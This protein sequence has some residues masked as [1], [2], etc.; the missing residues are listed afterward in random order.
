MNNILKK[1]KTVRNIFKSIVEKNKLSV[2]NGKNKVKGDNNSNKINS[3]LPQSF[4]CDV[5]FKSFASRVKLNE[6]LTS[7][8]HKLKL[9]K[10]KNELKTN[11]SANVNSSSVSNINEIK[12]DAPKL[13]AENNMLI[14]F[15]CNKETSSLP[16]L[17]NHLNESHSFEFPA[18]DCLK[19]L[20]KALKLII[21]KIFKYGSCL[22]CDSQRFPNPKS[23][24]THMRDSGHVKL[25]LDDL[26]DHFYKFYDFE[27]LRQQ[28]NKTKYKLQIGYK[29]I[30]KRFREEST[31]VKKSEIKEEIEEIS[32]ID[33]NLVVSD[34]ELDNNKM[35]N[36]TKKE[37][38]NDSVSDNDLEDI[39]DINYVELGN[40][41][42]L[43][44]DGTVLGNKLYKNA[45]R[46]RVKI[47]NE[48][49]K[50]Q[51]LHTNTLK[52]KL[53][54]SLRLKNRLKERKKMYSHWNV[55]GSLKGM[56]IRANTLHII[57]KQVNV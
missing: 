29:I 55:K 25:S 43:L 30:K 36:S 5:C 13:T 16:E 20:K 35:I 28:E 50:S 31:K 47:D 9:E 21:K 18:F 42:A 23:V 7:K 4:F 57:R 40:G 14:C 1:K 46:Q 53:K 38:D 34:E 12:K 37:N 48:I 56:F 26:Y 24:Q 27:K 19:N 41:E 44:P 52:L 11:E 17:I 15:A 3:D 33:Q 51:A 32:D 54:A 45:Y 2:K 8:S 6:H 10:G 39:E 22:Y 49:K